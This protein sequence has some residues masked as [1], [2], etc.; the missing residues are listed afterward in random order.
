MENSDYL[1]INCKENAIQIKCRKLCRKCYMKLRLEKKG[2][3]PDRNWM[4]PYS[5]EIEFIKNYFTHKNW[6]Y[7]PVIFRM[8]GF[9]YEPDFYDNERN[10][11]IEVAGTRQAY[12]EN[13]EKYKVFVDSFPHF[14]LEVRHINGN[15]IDIN[16]KRQPKY[17]WK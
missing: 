1:C 2:G 14:N 16:A 15:L 8:N 6:F 12:H 7:H 10:V 4:I 11:F 5:R 3:I 9:R 17:S 13:L